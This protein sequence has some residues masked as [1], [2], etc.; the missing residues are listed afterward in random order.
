[1]LQLGTPFNPRPLK[2]ESMLKMNKP[3]HIR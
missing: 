1:M 2:I 3:I